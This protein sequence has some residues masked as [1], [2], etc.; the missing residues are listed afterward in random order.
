MTDIVNPGRADR[1]HLAFS[2]GVGDLAR[3]VAP[4]LCSCGDP[5]LRLKSGYA[6]DHNSKYLPNSKLHH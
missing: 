4:I 2:G 5:S 1:R 3:S 6:Q